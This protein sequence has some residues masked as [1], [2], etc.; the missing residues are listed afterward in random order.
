MPPASRKDS[1]SPSPSGCRPSQPAFLLAQ[2]CAHAAGQFAKRLA[3]LQ[4]APPHVGILRI[5]DAAPAMAQQT[6]ATTLGDGSKPLGWV[7]RRSAWPFP[8]KE[9]D[10]QAARED[11]PSHV[12]SFLAGCSEGNLSGLLCASSRESIQRA[13][14]RVLPFTVTSTQTQCRSPRTPWL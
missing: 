6:L 10:D 3:E 9:R 11:I 4:I 12:S 5:L 8:Q 14:R 1:R 7:A 13:T 2:V